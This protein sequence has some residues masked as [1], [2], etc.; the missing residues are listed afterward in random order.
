MPAVADYSTEIQ[1]K[2][3]PTIPGYR[4]EVGAVARTCPPP[5][6]PTSFQTKNPDECRPEVD[7]YDLP[8]NEQNIECVLF[9]PEDFEAARRELQA[10]LAAKP[11]QAVTGQAKMRWLSNV[12]LQLNALWDSTNVKIDFLFPTLTRQRILNSTD[13]VSNGRKAAI[14]DTLTPSVIEDADRAFWQGVANRVAGDG[15]PLKIPFGLTAATQQFHY[16]PRAMWSYVRGQHGRPYGDV[17]LSDVTDTTLWL[18][19]RTSGLYAFAPTPAAQPRFTTNAEVGFSNTGAARQTAK[20]VTDAMYAS[21]GRG[22][23]LYTWSDRDL[24]ALLFETNP[25]LELAPGQ[26]KNADLEWRPMLVP[27][28]QVLLDYA[29]TI[30]RAALSVSY[31]DYCMDGIDRWLTHLMPWAEA[32]LL[33]LSPSAIGQAQR[34]LGEAKAHAQVQL[35]STAV[36]PMAAIGGAFAIVIAIAIILVNVLPLA[37]G[38]WQCPDIPVRRTVTDPACAITTVQGQPANVIAALRNMQDRS[39]ISLFRDAEGN[40]TLPPEP[41]FSMTATGKLVLAAFGVAGGA[42]VTKILTG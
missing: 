3:G 26:Y 4:G 11:A 31:L 8:C 32:G 21:E 34:G 38:G 14:A 15:R 28:G 10:L 6:P 41:D 12:V 19:S 33:D 37:V 29:E 1:R 2:I 39:D 35:F 22:R 20:P 42:I 5:Q 25:G 36:A 7:V 40:P 23:T 27:G 17:D 24:L 30:A 13:Q 16:S 18:E 9:R